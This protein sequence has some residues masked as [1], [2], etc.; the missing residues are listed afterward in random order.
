MMDSR[1]KEQKVRKKH[2]KETTTKNDEV[3]H[4]D[5]DNRHFFQ[6]GQQKATITP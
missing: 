4:H 3:L 5:I 1:Q 2:K 6:V